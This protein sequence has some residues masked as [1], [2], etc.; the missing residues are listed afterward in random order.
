MKEQL[1]NA[2]GKKK[3]TN[4]KGNKGNNNKMLPVKLAWQQNLT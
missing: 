3:T 1:K 4:G 2:V